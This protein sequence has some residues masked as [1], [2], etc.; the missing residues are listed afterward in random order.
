[1]FLVTGTQDGA[2]VRSEPTG[3]VR[4]F[5]QRLNPDSLL[6]KALDIGAGLVLGYVGLATGSL[7]ILGIA[8]ILLMSPAIHRYGWDNKVILIAVYLPLALVISGFAISLSSGIGTQ[9]QY[10]ALAVLSV[11]LF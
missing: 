6:A 11:L 1:M 4:R 7:A 9:S 5:L 10:L 8:S 3:G 2:A